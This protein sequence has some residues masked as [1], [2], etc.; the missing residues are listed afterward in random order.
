MVRCEGVD[1]S[2]CRHTTRARAASPYPKHRLIVVVDLLRPH[3]YEPVNTRQQRPF[4]AAEHFSVRYIGF[5]P[6]AD[7]FYKLLM[8]LG[9]AGFRVIAVDYPVYW[10]HEDWCTCTLAPLLTLPSFALRSMSPGTSYADGP[11]LRCSLSHADWR[12]D[13]YRIPHSGVGFMKLLDQLGLDTV[14]L[15]G[16]SLGGF[17]AQ[18]FAEY[19]HPVSTV[20]ICAL[21]RTLTSFPGDS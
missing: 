8:T 2:V 21:C 3:W 17:L 5:S 7:G 6:P 10:K 13:D 11:G 14:H 18:K 4:L 12:S 15:F 9:A 20:P 1:A 19:V 16:A